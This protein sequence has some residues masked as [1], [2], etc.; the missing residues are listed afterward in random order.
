MKMIKQFT[1]LVFLIIFLILTWTGCS[2]R[3]ETPVTEADS[4][5]VYNSKKTDGISAGITLYRYINKKT[6]NLIGK[7]TVFPIREKEKLR[8][9]INIKNRFLHF[10]H[11]LMFHVDW[12]GTNGRSFYRKQINL[13]PGDSSTTIKTSISIPPEKREPGKYYI[14][15][16][17]Y[18]ELIAE[19]KFELIPET[20]YIS[21]ISE[22]I[23]AGITLYRKKSS[24]TG[25]LLGEGN[26][27]TIKK[28]AKVRAIVELEN[29]S[30]YKNGE[31]EFEIDW[32]QEGGESIYSKKINMNTEGTA[33]TIKSSL[34]IAPKKRKAGNYIFKVL[35]YQKVIAE[36]KFELLSETVS[37]K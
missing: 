12:I 18:R 32:K 17:L 29:S 3:Y 26:V 15:I 16:Y 14:R 13:S 23:N 22:K 25:K 27:F 21:S 5:I 35:L 19:K 7:G 6:G 34:S 1:F 28:K 33:L 9:L 24:K 10:D 30:D 20:Q 4:T 36:K 11:E 31:L 2:S 37:K 8:A